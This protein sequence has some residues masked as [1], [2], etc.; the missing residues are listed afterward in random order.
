MK[1]LKFEYRMELKFSSQVTGH[2]FS[3]RC[4]PQDSPRQKIRLEKEQI[5]PADYIVSAGDGFGNKKISGCCSG[6]H[7]YFGYY[8]AGTAFIEKGGWQKSGLHPM[9]RYPSKYTGLEKEV[10]AFA[11]AV[12]QECRN[13]YA[14]TDLE[15][16]VCAMDYLY[17][18]FQYAPGVTDTGTTAEEALR[19]GK[20]VCQDYAHIMI[21]A[22]RYMGIPARYVNGLMIGEGCS[23]AWTEVYADGGWY[24]LDPT[25]DRLVDDYYIKL[26]HG[27]DYGDCMID[28]GRF[29]G[30]VSQ[31]QDI[32]V[33]VE[34][35]TDDRNSCVN[36]TA[37][38]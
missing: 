2:Y 8:I 19:L 22:M 10:S 21:A 30:N 32:Y 5:A 13:K 27:R 35:I 20:G 24:G 34:E 29:L 36:G 25:N 3:L 18:H 31:K 14:E 33:K 6:P 17:S 37:G 23:H 28:Q 7:D 26:A 38:G 9:Y 15:K 16:A 12:L 1:K 4:V 11:E